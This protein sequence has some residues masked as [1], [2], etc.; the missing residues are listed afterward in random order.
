MKFFVYFWFWLIV[1]A[2][3]FI[4]I[5]LTMQWLQGGFIYV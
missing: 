5:G 4:V 1:F 3:T 2:F